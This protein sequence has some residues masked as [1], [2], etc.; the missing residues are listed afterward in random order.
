MKTGYNLLLSYR[1]PRIILAVPSWILQICEV[2]LH[3]DILGSN[4]VHWLLKLLY[5]PIFSFYGMPDMLFFPAPVH[6]NSIVEQ[7]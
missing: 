2:R 6:M 7:Q 3:A 5:G 1:K 4:P